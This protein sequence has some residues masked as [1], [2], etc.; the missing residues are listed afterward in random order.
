ML[1]SKMKIYLSVKPS[2]KVYIQKPPSKKILSPKIIVLIPHKIFFKQKQVVTL[3]DRPLFKFLETR[4]TYF[5]E[6]ANNTGRLFK[7]SFDI[8][9]L[10]QNR[11]HIVNLKYS[12]T[13]IVRDGAKSSI[14]SWMS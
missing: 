10:S 6:K 5:W 9:S 3:S 4:R 8:F 7:N 1:T 14:N 11:L 2:Q 12:F 13:L